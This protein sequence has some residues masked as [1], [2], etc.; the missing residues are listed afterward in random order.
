MSLASVGSLLLG[1]FATG[2]VQLEKN[3]GLPYIRLGAIVQMG[4]IVADHYVNFGNRVVS[5]YRPNYG[6][7]RCRIARR[8][9][10]CMTGQWA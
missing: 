9:T 5:A 1:I 8:I 6:V 10:V 4:M 7:P 3:S 2:R